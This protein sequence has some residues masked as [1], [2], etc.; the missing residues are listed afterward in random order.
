[1][2]VDAIDHLVMT[3]RS[4][5]ATCEFYSKVLGTRILISADDRKA[6][7]IGSQKLNLH[8]QGKEF[9][10]A[11]AH[12]TPGA[13]DVCLLTMT[14]LSDVINHLQSVGV[15]VID[16]PVQR[17]GAT[18]PILSVYFRDPDSNLIEISNILTPDQS[19]DK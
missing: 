9:S 7:R 15:E 6:L 13:I 10:P 12:P 8:E 4:I 5:E 1:M 11:A 16:G 19:S 2:Q 18:G 14:P 3:V 17:T